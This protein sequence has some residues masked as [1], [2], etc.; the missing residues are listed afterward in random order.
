MEKVNPLFT[1]RNRERISQLEIIQKFLV[2]MKKIY[3]RNLNEVA[4]TQPLVKKFIKLL[5]DD[6][7]NLSPRQGQNIEVID[8]QSIKLEMSIVTSNPK[9]IAGYT[10]LIIM[11]NRQN[12]SAKH[13]TKAILKTIK[14]ETGYSDLFDRVLCHVEVKS[15]FGDFFHSSATKSKFQAIA[16]TLLL[17]SKRSDD[18]QYRRL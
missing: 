2:W 6:I 15:P 5:V 9:T 18:F 14:T 4:M 10:D 1:G 12:Q 8:A 16:E 13:L 17:M 3:N 7:L 11:E